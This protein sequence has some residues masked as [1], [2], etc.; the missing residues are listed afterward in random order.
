VMKRTQ[1]GSPVNVVSDAGSDRYDLVLVAVRREQLAPALND[2][3]S[4]VERPALVFFGNN[5]EGRAAVPSDLPGD[6]FLGFPGIGGSMV[7]GVAEYVLIP[8]Q[9]TNFES[10]TDGRLIEIMETLRRRGFAVHSEKDMNG[11]LVYHAVFVSCV[12]AALYRCG[13]DPSRLG[14][15]DEPLGGRHIQL[16]WKLNFFLNVQELQMM[17]SLPKL[18]AISTGAKYLSI[19]GC[20]S[21]YRKTNIGL[22]ERRPHSDVGVD[23]AQGG[24]LPHQDRNAEL[25]F[26]LFPNGLVEFLHG[27]RTVFVVQVVVV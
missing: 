8:Q 10:T 17:R 16:L 21:Q 2:V 23:G 22:I 3:R 5:P 27:G 9:P 24:V 4:L 25:F 13:T 14:L 1:A 6:V 19:R 26:L 12:A 7:D 20:R 15:G 11:W 18:L